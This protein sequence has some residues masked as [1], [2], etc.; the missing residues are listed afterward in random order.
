MINDNFKAN[1]LK[2]LKYNANVEILGESEMLKEEIRIPL[3]PIKINANLLYYFFE[4]LYPKFINDQQN[5][6]DIIVSD[7]GKE[8]LSLYLYETKKAGIHKSI[9]RVPKNLFNLQET[10]LDDLD[11]FFK[12]LQLILLE[13]G[14]LKISSLRIFK[15]KAVDLINEYCSTV[16]ELSNH[17]FLHNIMNLIQNLLVEDKFYL[18]PESNIYKFIKKSIN[19]LKGIKL[20]NLF[21]FI[22]EILPDFNTSIVFNSDKLILILKFSKKKID[23]EKLEIEFEFFTPEDLGIDIRD[24][25]IENILTHIQNIL[26][27]DKIYFL[28]QNHMISFL[29]NIFE[30]EIPF[31]MDKLLLLCQKALFGFRNFE[32][33]WYMIPRPRVYNNLRRFITRLFGKNL[34]LKKVSHW[35]LSELISNSIDSYFG[36]NSKILIILTD[37]KKFKLNKNYLKN[38]FKFALLLEIENRKLVKIKS[39]KKDAILFDDKINSLELIRSKISETY[40]FV[41]AVINID[42]ILLNDII[43]NFGLK[44]SKFKPLSKTKA[45]NILRKSYYFNMYPEVPLVKFLKHNGLISFFKLLL[46]ILIDKHEF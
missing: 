29:L 39:L 28:N 6:L 19:F 33:F 7:N 2:I 10:D 22:Y 37:I 25:K 17:E 21:E 3:T 38:A 24:L 41:S 13:K 18:Y 34:N 14:E 40:G 9:Q 27:S 32:N 15:K 1:W 11:K 23:A 35:A 31:R 4:L 45:F 20:T 46:P 42:K 5:I 36:L 43:D 8:I 44:L 30:L 12:K 16:E 26:K